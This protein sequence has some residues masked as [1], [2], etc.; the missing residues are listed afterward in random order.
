[1]D[2]VSATELT[3]ATS[4]LQANLIAARSEAQHQQQVADVLS[5][6]AQ[7]AQEQVPPTSNPEGVGQNVDT[8]A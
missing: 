4:Q 8:Y 1:M 6:Q 2:G 7:K 5:Q 3:Q